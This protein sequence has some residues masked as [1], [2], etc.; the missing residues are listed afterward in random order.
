MTE[1]NKQCLSVYILCS[2]TFPMFLDGCCLGNQKKQTGGN[3]R[4]TFH[5]RYRAVEGEDFMIPCETLN[6]SMVSC[7]MT[8]EGRDGNE[9]LSF[10][11]GRD[12][13]AEAKHSGK[14]TCSGS[15]MFFHLQVV[16][17]SLGC[18]QSN[19]IHKSVRLTVDKGGEIPCPGH[20]CSNNREIIWYKHNRTVS[21]RYC[22][23]PGWLHLCHVIK[24]DAGVYF[25][26][27]QIIEEGVIWTFRRAVHVTVNPLE[28]NEPPSIIYPNGNMKEEVELGRSH[29]LMCKA[30]FPFEADVSPEV[31]WYINY[32]G[33][34]ENMTLLRMEEQHEERVTFEVLEVI[35]RASIK[36][37]TP[38]LLNQNPTFTCIANN[39][40]GN[41]NVTIKL[42]EKMKVK[43][44]SLVGYPVVPLLLVA[45]LGMVLH[46][47]WLEIQ[48]I[49]RSHFQHGKHDKDKKEFDVL[50]SYVWSP[51]TAELEVLTI[52]SQKGPDTDE[53]ACLS[54]MDPLNTEE[55][56]S[57]H[58]PLEVLLPH[59]LEDRWAY[60]LCLLER[61]VLPGGAYAND[62]ILAMQRCRM[63]ICLLSADYLSNSNA[64]FVLES[65][66]QALLQNSSLKVL[67][68][69]T[70][71]AS[72]S[73]IQP[74]P[75]LPTL[76][77]RALKVLP[78]LVWT[79]GDSSFWRS[80]RKA[81]PD[82]RVKLV[83]L[84]QDQ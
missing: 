79:P 60:R 26:D 8:G 19:G 4:G 18:L 10:V 29:T 61:D 23:K 43:W 57:I 14:Y 32:S 59:V 22:Q 5:Q 80:L 71:G 39:T 68:I 81:M 33:K 66:I 62:V 82:Q 77:Q 37:V 44:P 65:G 52:S 1:R 50:L 73:L 31:R 41:S 25:C 83:S 74:D 72:A 46:V 6:R 56:N 3:Q 13:R 78:S 40:H 17:R 51:P 15:K 7:S 84:M 12:F 55:G 69:W 58:R 21:R 48:L 64:V 2:F 38:Q 42:I 16:N 28:S 47:K 20:N 36:E 63:L 45:G 54:S 24:E 35:R 49:Y 70:S 76:V 75:P 30:R 53:E 34:M 11:C 67:L 27:R 9:G